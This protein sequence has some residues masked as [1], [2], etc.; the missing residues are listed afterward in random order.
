MTKFYKE[1]KFKDAKLG[2]LQEEWEVVKLG[3]VAKISS[4]GSAPQGAHYFNGNHP[5]IRVQH[6][7]YEDY[8]IRKYDLI[9]DNAINDYRLSLYSKGTIVFPKSGAS[10]YLEKRAIL[11]TDAYI[12]S[13]LCAVISNEE[14]VLQHFLFYVLISLK[15]AKKK[16]SGY[17]TLNLSEVKQ[18]K[19]PLPPLPEQKK[20]AAVLSAVQETKEKTEEVI[21]AAKELKKSL[22]KHLF[23]YGTVSIFKKNSIK[24]KT[25]LLGNVPDDWRVMRINE[26]AKQ[27]KLINRSKKISDV[28]SVTKHQ[29]IL[30]SKSYFKRQV[31][32]KDLSTYKIIKK[33][34][35]AY[36]TIHLNE[37]AIGYLTCFDEAVLSPM[38]TVFE[39]NKDVVLPY[40]L[41]CLL[42]LEKLVNI[43]NTLGVG[44]VHR[45][46][47][48]KYSEFSRLEIPIPPLSTQE[49][50][51]LILNSINKKIE[52]EENKKKAL[53]ELFKTLLNNLMIGKIIVHDL[54]IE[55]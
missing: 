19:I 46:M 21:K 1:T 3:D 14:S 45:R 2:L 34:Q 44:A 37:G 24:T 48:I 50:I 39:V 27:I 55:V 5:F 38:Y 52:A 20:I 43:F 9:T 7:D 49:N 35:F 28:V 8:V 12:V 29:G 53:K 4:G 47:A 23:T 31:Y 17:P 33:Y 16:A 13:H 40:F 11:P 32:S 18:I 36:A 15:L 22:M 42:K 25:T 26:F 10:V 41:Y 30:P 6:I 51:V 54:D